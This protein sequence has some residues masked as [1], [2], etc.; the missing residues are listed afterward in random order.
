[1]RHVMTQGASCLAMLTAIASVC[2]ADTPYAQAVKSLQPTYY[3]QLNEPDASGGVVDAMGN[4]EPG[5]YNGERYKGDGHL[6]SRRLEWRHGVRQRRP[7]ESLSG[8]RRRCRSARQQ[9]ACPGTL[10]PDADALGSHCM[11]RLATHSRLTI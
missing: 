1:M 4:A 5:S 3:Y 10:G 6:G 8:E 2:A 11:G 7:R 9:A